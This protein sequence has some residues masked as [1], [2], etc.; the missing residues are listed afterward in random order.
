MKRYRFPGLKAHCIEHKEFVKKAD[1]YREQFEMEMNPLI[2]AMA[3]L[4]FLKEWL[5]N[6]ILKTDKQYGPFLNEKG[7]S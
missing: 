7:I 5:Q 3:I 2:L 1:E 4:T 6:H